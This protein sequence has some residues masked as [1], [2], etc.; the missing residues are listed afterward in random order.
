MNQ[1]NFKL[2]SNRD[3]KRWF[4]HSQKRITEIKNDEDFLDAF[5]DLID[6]SLTEYR[7]FY[8]KLGWKT[9]LM[10]RCFVYFHIP[11]MVENIEKEYTIN[12]FL[13]RGYIYIL[14]ML[15]RLPLLEFNQ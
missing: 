12:E 6:T 11:H 13:I 4:L 15:K 1:S 5:V 8:M 10:F 9:G 2:D 14:N 7:N 3:T